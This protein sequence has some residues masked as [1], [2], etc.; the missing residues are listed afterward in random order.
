[1]MVNHQRTWH[2]EVHTHFTPFFWS[3]YHDSVL[4]VVVAVI[5][6]TSW[7]HLQ[8]VTSL[9]PPNICNPADIAHPLHIT[10]SL[11]LSSVDAPVDVHSISCSFLLIYPREVCLAWCWVITRQLFSHGIFLLS[12]PLGAGSTGVGLVHLSYAWWT[13]THRETTVSGVMRRSLLWWRIH[14]CPCWSVT[15]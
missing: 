6:S 7:W 2:R 8:A 3:C 9:P 1:M 12:L 4:W 11:H 10:W 5:Q 13:P 15:L 14:D